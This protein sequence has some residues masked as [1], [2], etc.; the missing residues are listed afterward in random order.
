[1]LPAP[2]IHRV[3]AIFVGIGDHFC[4]ARRAG[5]AP[6]GSHHGAW[7]RLI[8]CPY[9]SAI[10]SCLQESTTQSEN[11]STENS[12]QKAHSGFRSVNSNYDCRWVG[13]RAIPVGKYV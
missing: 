10:L 3:A 5:I 9:R 1:M 2:E 12:K 8:R 13:F 4:I 6:P 11:Q 7:N